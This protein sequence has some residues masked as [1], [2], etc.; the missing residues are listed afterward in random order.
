[1]VSRVLR[2]LGMLE[3]ATYVLQDGLN[4]KDP[5]EPRRTTA[6]IYRELATLLRLDE[7]KFRLSEIDD[8]LNTRFPKEFDD[9]EYW[10]ARAYNQAWTGDLK[11]QTAR[12]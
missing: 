3:E 1:M 4:N 6:E 8:Y 9:P 11:N 10:L 7:D 2:R 12:K 5:S